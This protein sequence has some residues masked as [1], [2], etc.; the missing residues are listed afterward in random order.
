[1]NHDYLWCTLLVSTQP[2]CKTDL[3][4]INKNVQI[5]KLAKMVKKKS[6]LVV[7]VIYIEVN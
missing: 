3:L 1:M 7:I 6:K 2:A 5:S 4:K